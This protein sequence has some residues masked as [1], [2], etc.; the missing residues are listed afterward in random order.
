M[1]YYSIVFSIIISATAFGQNKIEIPY[2]YYYE[3]DQE[4]GLHYEKGDYLLTV[5]YTDDTLSWSA[6]STYQLDVCHI[7]KHTDKYIVAQSKDGTYVFYSITDKRLFYLIK[8]ET[9]Y[10]AY[11]VGA[12]S[13]A[14]RETVGHMMH[15]IAEGGAIEDV[16]AFLSKQ[17]SYDF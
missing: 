12:G 8:W 5:Q 10:T 16:I 3:Y 7:K 4:Y 6:D 13:L 17:A 1:K 15:E 11:G 9:T 14:L 2:T